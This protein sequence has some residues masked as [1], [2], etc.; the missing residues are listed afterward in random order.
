MREQRSMLD[1]AI[2]ASLAVLPVLL[3]V[4]LLVA[5]IR[6]GRDTLS[7]GDAAADDRHVSVRHVAA[8]KTFESAIVR[9]DSADF[10]PPRAADADALLQA[11]PECRRDWQDTPQPARVAAQLASID[12]ALQ[13]FSTRPN[14]RVESALG[15]DARRWSDAARDALAASLEA[16]QYPGRSF[17]LGCADL[18]GAV[19]ALARA[20]ARMLD[21][22]AWRGTVPAATLA[23]WAPQQQV[24]ITARHV[25]RRNP[26]SGLAGCVYLGAGGA[27]THLVAAAGAAQARACS[28]PAM[29]AASPTPLPPLQH[30]PGEPTT[31]LAAGDARWGVPPSLSAM[32]A[33]LDALRQPSRGLYR[34]YTEPGTDGGDDGAD[35]SAYRFGPNRLVL[36]GTPIDVG[37]SLQLTIDPALQ[38]LSQKTAACYT[39]DAPACRALGVHRAEDGGQPP[40][41]RLLEGAMV[42]MAAVAVVDVASGRID[43]LAGALSPCARQEVDGPGR[44]ARCD[45]RLPWAVRYRPDALLNPAVWHDAMPASTIKPVIATAL[46]GDTPA[47][48]RLLAAERSAMQRPGTPAPRSLRGEL[49]R[50]D[51]ARFLDRMLCLDGSGEQPCRRPWDVQAAATALG[52]NAGCGAAAGSE[53]C[54]RHDLLFG[55]AIDARADGADGGL[56]QPL[57]T[58]VAFG[59]LMSEPAAPR[60]G[61]PMRLAP[62]RPLDPATVQRCAAGAD[63]ARG[64][65]D[66]WEKCR[67]GRV[68]DIV[69][70]GWG[71]G[72]ARA[73]ALGVAGMLAR[74]AAAAN[75]LDAV[76]RP[77]LVERIHGVGGR[78]LDAAVTRYRLDTP[79]PVGIGHDAAEVILSGLS[80]SHREGTARTACEQVFD[81]KRCRQIDWLAGKTGTPS[82]PNDGTSLDELATLC[83]GAPAKRRAPAA[84]AK[85]AKP[86]TAADREAACSS[87]RPYKWYVAAVRSDPAGPWTKVIAVLAE[88]NW[89]RATGQVHGAG[90]RGPNPAAEIAL[91]IAG[92]HVGALT[93]ALNSAPSGASSGASERRTERTPAMNPPTHPTPAE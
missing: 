83:H 56:V 32:L 44:D 11:L 25:M 90:D 39:G 12:A 4:L 71:Q 51:S 42:R 66:D 5:V 80:H 46:L 1:L 84:A 13:R 59:R 64:S 7:T 37:F 76:R 24:Q 10:A 52:W 23:R 21:A 26:W 79:Q 20:D 75:G 57:A 29:R 70:E 33:P 22:L 87:L 68:V 69:A 49:L 27:A 18:A 61:A 78:P 77:H 2:A 74:I 63:G 15:I 82:F 86:M 58:P 72:H 50:S 8:L 81:A 9:R 55:R 93:G 67:G 6:P 43:A 45:R 35:P 73:T 65:D 3:G 40:G 62:P 91:Q 38:A 54:G 14:R 41:Q 36:D 28:D 30:L 19:A 53:H 47:G 60:L 92:R 88:R 31:A 17:R 85:A 48:R 16:P 89:L 34:L